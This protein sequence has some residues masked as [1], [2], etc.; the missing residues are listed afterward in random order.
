M[1]LSEERQIELAAALEAMNSGEEAVQEEAQE[2]VAPVEAQPEEAEETL[3]AG[4]HEAPEGADDDDSEDEEGHA[5]PYSRFSK[6]I[7]AKNQFAEEVESLKAQVDKLQE[8]EEELETLRR[9]GMGQKQ[10]EVVEEIEDYD[11]DPYDKRLQQLESRLADNEREATIQKHMTEMEKEIAAIQ[12]Q[13]PNVDPIKLLQQVQ[14]NPDVNLLELAVQEA[15][16]SAELREQIIA[17]YLKENPEAQVQ[18]DA[19]KEAPDIPPEVQN[20]SSSTNRGHA[21]QKAPSTWEDAH[22]QA[23]QA[24]KAAWTG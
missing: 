4:E 19:A 22:V 11:S 9:Y 13:Y 16:Q 21:G 17:E 5:V 7:A 23:A 2:P 20:K 10:Q 18:L 24:L 12:Q 1:E 15:S 3:E 6:V 8:K 14:H